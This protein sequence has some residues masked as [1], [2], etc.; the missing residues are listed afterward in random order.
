PAGGQGKYG[1]RHR[2]Q[3]RRREDRRL[4][5]RLGTR[6]WGAGWPRGGGRAAREDRAIQGL[7]YGRI[8]AQGVAGRRLSGRL[9][10]SA[11][12]FDAGGYPDASCSSLDSLLRWL[13]GG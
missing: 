12:V 5:D 9:N 10:R 8:P 1:R 6:G 2:A 4:G 13:I 3:S 11:G 7:S